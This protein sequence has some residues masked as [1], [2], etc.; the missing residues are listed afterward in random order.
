MPREAWLGLL[1]IGVAAAVFFTFAIRHV[2]RIERE[3]IAA[4][5]LVLPSYALEGLQ[6]VFRGQA[7]GV[8]AELRLVQRSGAKT[9]G[10][11]WTLVVV[12]RPPS[13]SFE[14]RPQDPLQTAEVRQGLAKDVEVG[15]LAFDRAF[16][17][18]V[19]PSDAAI[20]ALDDELRRLLL[21]LRP[22]WVVETADGH[23]RLERRDWETGRFGPLVDVAARLAEQLHRAA[24]VRVGPLAARAEAG[25]TVT[26]P[27]SGEQ[28]ELAAMR[29][30]RSR[31]RLRT[32]ILV[33]V[34]LLA[35]LAVSL[36]RR[37]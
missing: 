3:A 17:V 16:I 35:L 4:A 36:L 10:S 25:G 34:G 8:E 19:A 37:P 6:H 12:P 1:A 9:T 2:N 29:A 31:A 11:L 13:V 15:D 32:V 14:L 22:V 23:L 5:R 21:D 18:E 7:R 30:R 24:G 26:D 27:V 33:V 20:G 28:A